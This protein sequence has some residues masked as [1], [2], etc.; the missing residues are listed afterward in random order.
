MRRLV[1]RV[2]I[3]CVSLVM[4]AGAGFDSYAIAEPQ[5]PALYQLVLNRYRVAV[6]DMWSGQ[7]LFNNDMSI[8]TM[9]PY[10]YYITEE[11]EK[12]LDKIGFCL[13]DI[14]G[15]GSEELLI[16]NISDDYPEKCIY[17]VYSIVDGEVK[18]VLSSIERERFFI[19]ADGMIL[20]DGSSGASNS[21][22]LW[23]ELDTK[24]GQL[25][26][27]YGIRSDGVDDNG[28]LICY[29]ESIGENERAEQV[30]ISSEEYGK[31]RE[32]YLD[33]TAQLSMTPFRKVKL[34]RVREGYY[35][36]VER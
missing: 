21:S 8:L 12:R 10:V 16:G 25:T 35:R 4:M 7:R 17:D 20:D 29:L 24:S 15:D 28:E 2:G 33:E 26:E 1:K 14:D 13:L 27:C 34:R 22:M 5:M 3:I 19:N 11:P 30:R 9:Y 32:K 23:G 18:R 31:I 36:R 6:E